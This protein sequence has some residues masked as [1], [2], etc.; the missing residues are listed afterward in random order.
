[1]KAIRKTSRGLETRIQTYVN[2]YDKHITTVGAMHAATEESWRELINYL[3]AA[4]KD[5]A[6]IHLEGVQ[7]AEG[8]TEDEKTGIAALLSLMALGRSVA[9][10]TGL[11]YQK[12]AFV[13][14]PAWKAHDV[15]VLDV[16]RKMNKK[17]LLYI[18]NIGSE[19]IRISPSKALWSLRNIH[20]LSF[21]GSFIPLTR[22]IVGSE[23]ILHQRNYF[24]TEAAFNTQ[25]DVVLV[26][27]AAHLPGMDKILRRNGYRRESTEWRVII[28]A[29]FT[30]PAGRVAL[31]AA[32]QV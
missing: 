24:A 25:S 11:Q 16:V 23:G 5:G 17:I 12:D 32:T 20:I 22:Q 15:T 18:A 19:D 30:A 9:E 4:E 7:P 8:T 21:F 6:E 10:L 3:V 14:A 1:M 26:W 13:N 27:G 29:G 31:S 28:P 2:N